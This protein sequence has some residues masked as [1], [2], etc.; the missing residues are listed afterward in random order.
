MDSRGSIYTDPVL[1]QL[2]WQEL[3]TKV[4]TILLHVFFPPKSMGKNLSSKSKLSWMCLLFKICKTT[5]VCWVG[6]WR[7]TILYFTFFKK[8]CPNYSCSTSSFFEEQKLLSYNFLEGPCWLCDSLY[9]DPATNL[10]T[11][12][13]H[14][15]PG[16]ASW[17]IAKLPPKITEE[18]TSA[19]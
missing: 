8:S 17:E 14:S 7:S 3:S 18:G 5:I 16:G 10:I 11:K 9:S 15:L 1:L 6:L 2:C 12:H 4:S 19:K 13:S